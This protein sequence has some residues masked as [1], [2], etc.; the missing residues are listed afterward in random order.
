[1]SAG[2]DASVRGESAEVPGSQKLPVMGG[3]DAPGRDYVEEVLRARTEVFSR[4][5]D[6]HYAQSAWKSE[7]WRRL[8]EARVNSDLHR[9]KAYHQA[10]L[11]GEYVIIP[12]ED[13]TPNFGPTMA[14]LNM[15]AQLDGKSFK[16]IVLA[17]KKKY[18][19]DAME[20]EVEARRLD[21]LAC[22]VREFNSMGFEEREAA[23]RRLNANKPEDAAWREANF[24]Q[25]VRVNERDKLLYL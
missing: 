2:E 16:V 6:N 13:P 24:P 3:L 19:I 20:Q 10:F 15:G 4:R 11:A 18:Q 1:M 14:G 17:D 9:H 23:I 21:W 5:F 7:E 25:G 12:A 8:Q 22:V